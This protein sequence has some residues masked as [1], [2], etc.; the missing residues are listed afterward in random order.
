M[1]SDLPSATPIRIVDDPAAPAYKKIDPDDTHPYRQK[2]IV[3][4]V[5]QR[6]SGRKT[7]T[8]YDIQ[9][10]RKVYEIDSKPNYYYKSKFA[11]PQYSNA[12]I[13]W[14]VEQFNKDPDFFDKIR[15]RCKDRIHA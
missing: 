12:F 15:R 2:E 13:D 5:N 4:F 6:L 1:E 10:V 11:S 3:Q 14:L 9:C 7:I 8:P